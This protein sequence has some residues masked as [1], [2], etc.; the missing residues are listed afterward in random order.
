MAKM[1]KSYAEGLYETELDLL[2]DIKEMGEN[3]KEW[4]W[5]VPFGHGWITREF[6][7]YTRDHRKWS[8]YRLGLRLGDMRLVLDVSNECWQ[9]TQG[10]F[11]SSVN[12][13][14]S[15]IMQELNG[16]H[17]DALQRVLNHR[18]STLILNLYCGSARIHNKWFGNM[19]SSC[20]LGD[21]L[22]S[23]EI[24]NLG[25]HTLRLD[26][27]GCVLRDLLRY[28]G[29]LLSCIAQESLFASLRKGK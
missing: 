20:W 4:D 1:N 26:L 25:L 12:R 18:F 9:P 15:S 23:R 7:V 27:R 13:A 21:Y 8:M 24:E 19:V 2:A 16:Y 5:E 17:Y 14:F 10:S 28:K 3:C 22:L 29:E 11:N 6:R